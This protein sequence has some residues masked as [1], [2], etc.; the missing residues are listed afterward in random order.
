MRSRLLRIAEE[1]WRAKARAA[2]YHV[3]ALAKQCRVSVRTLERQI[4]EQRDKS[5]HAWLHELRMIE[6]RVLLLDDN[7]VK[8]TAGMLGYKDT[9]QFSKDF[10]QYYSALPSRMGKKLKAEMLKR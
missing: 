8:E 7:S 10:K 1:E 5:P 3:G 2:N 6:A 4:K 9:S